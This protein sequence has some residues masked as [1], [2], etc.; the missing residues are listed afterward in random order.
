VD[1]WKVREL[2]L[3]TDDA[4]QALMNAEA[5]EGWSLERVDYIKE[6]GVRRPQM[7]YF[8]FR[9]AVPVTSPGDEPND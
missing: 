9:R 5:A 1:A 2:Q 3:V 8:F 7:A 4:V 6:V